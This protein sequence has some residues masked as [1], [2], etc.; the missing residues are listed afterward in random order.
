VVLKI[1]LILVNTTQVGWKLLA[2]IDICTSIF[3]PRSIVT[4]RP[5]Y[6]RE[7]KRK[8]NKYLPMRN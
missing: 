7:W 3:I 1:N 8:A 2:W 4:V 6:S 5:W